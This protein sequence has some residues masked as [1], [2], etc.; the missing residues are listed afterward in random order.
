MHLLSVFS[1]RN[2]ALIALLTIV[3]A[4]FGAFA[5]STLKQDLFPS[6]NI[7]QLVIVTTYPGASPDVVETDVSTPIETAIQG[8]PG[9]D[10]TVATST[11]G[12]STVSASFVY[13]TNIATAEQ[14]VQLAIN[15]LTTLPDAAQVNVLT[16]SLDD[17]PVIQIAVTSDLDSDEL[18]ARLEASTIT[19]IQQLDGVR[20]AALLGTT[21]K[22]VTITPDLDTLLANGFTSQ[23]IRDALK[24]NGVLLAAGQI[25][26]DG[27]TLTV[28]AGQ[29]LATADDIAALPLLGGRGPVTLPDGSVVKPDRFTIG[30][31]ADV[32]VVDNPITSIS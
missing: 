26:E 6:L 12:A 30:D 23:S 32:E 4:G 19:D 31:L 3:V 17:F 21:G 18:S 25:T 14:K 24:N 8:V 29:R 20:E 22:R 2:R 28:Q 7:P 9:L 1:L 15:R 11:S 27:S 5:L 16:G 13:G 10:G